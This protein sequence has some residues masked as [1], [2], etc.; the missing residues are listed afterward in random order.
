ARQCA[1]TW[2][3]PMPEEWG[4]SDATDL[5]TGPRLGPVLQAVAVHPGLWVVAL[6]QALRLARPRWWARWPPIPTPDPTFWRFR[7][8][9]AYGGDGDGIPTKEDVRAYLKWCQ[10]RYR[11]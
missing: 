5:V 6:S 8:Q 1:G 4:S 9:T 2:I 7:V 11:R 3:K 10:A